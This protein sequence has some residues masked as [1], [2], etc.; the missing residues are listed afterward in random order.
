MGHYFWGG[1]GI[2]FGGDG[3]LLGFYSIALV[4]RSFIFLLGMKIDI[5][6]VI[7]QFWANFLRDFFLAIFSLILHTA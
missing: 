5:E 4:L 6:T 3:L 7:P 2:I 1:V